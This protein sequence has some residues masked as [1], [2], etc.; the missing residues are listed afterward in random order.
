[1]RAHGIR[2]A[3]LVVEAFVA[4]TAVVGGL[5]LVTGLEGN[6]FPL[7]LLES[8]PFSSFVAPGL[9]LTIVVGGS[10]TLAV[11]ALLRGLDNSAPASIIA[12]AILMGWIIGEALLLHLPSW[13]EAF[14]FALGVTMVAL[15]VAGNW[16]QRKRR[17]SPSGRS[18]A[19]V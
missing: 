11:I 6:R 19:G 8:T 3:L 12:G 17:I 5:A 16:T 18:M 14:Y 1:M 10:A 13:F 2:I 9:T 15:G 4:V 7:K